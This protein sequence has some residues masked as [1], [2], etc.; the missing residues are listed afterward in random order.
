VARINPT[1]SVVKIGL[2]AAAENAN[3]SVDL[4]AVRYA[5]LALKTGDT[6][7]LSPK[8]IRVF[9]PEEQDYVI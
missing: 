4:S 3:L 9:V 2:V 7:W 5:E 1:G 6:V 8:K